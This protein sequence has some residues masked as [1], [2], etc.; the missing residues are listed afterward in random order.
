MTYILNFYQNSIIL[1][2]NILKMEKQNYVW[3]HAPIAY[4]TGSLSNRIEA[5]QN[6]SG[7]WE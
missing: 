2:Q 5:Y 6:Q 1:K 4:V 7:S 3:T